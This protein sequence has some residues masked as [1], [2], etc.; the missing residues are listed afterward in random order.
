MTFF[1]N[2]FALYFVLQIYNKY[3]LFYGFFVYITL[4]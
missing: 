3:A 1:N 2:S 4:F